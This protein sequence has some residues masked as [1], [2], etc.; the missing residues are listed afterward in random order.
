MSMQKIAFLV[1]VAV[2]LW[3]G[4]WN[5]HSILINNNSAVYQSDTLKDSTAFVKDPLRLASFL[6]SQDTARKDTLPKP[7]VGLQRDTTYR[8][9]TTAAPKVAALQTELKIASLAHLS[10]CPGVFVSVSFIADGPFNDGNEFTVQIADATGKFTASSEPAK[11]GPLRTLIPINRAG[12]FAVRV[13][14]SSPYL[15]SKPTQIY[16]LPLPTARIEFTDG[17]FMTKIGPGQATTYRVNLTGAAPWSFTLSDGTTVTNTFINPYTATVQPTQTTAYKATD[18]GNV[19]GSGT[20]SGEVIVQVSQDT[21]PVIALKAV[22]KGGYRVCS[23]AALQVNF[24][25]TGKYQI[26]NGFVVQLADSLSEKFVNISEL[27]ENPVVAKIPNNLTPGR[28]KMRLVS[29]FP[30]QSSDTADVFVSATTTTLLRTDSLEVAEGQSANLT[31]EFKG[32]EPWFVLLSDGTY[33]NDI[34][35]SIY[36]I[37]VMPYNSAVYSI[38]SAGGYC[39]VGDFSGRAYVNVKIPPTTLST[40]NLSKQTICAGTEIVVPFTSTGRFY[41]ANQFVVQI[42]DTAGKWVNLPTTGAAGS[43]RA[44]ISPP[45]LRD[46]ISVQQIRVISTAPAAQGTPTTLKVYKPNVAE[47][48]V[49]GGGFIRPGGASRLKVTF[50]NGLPPYSFTLSDGTLVNGT[51]INPYQMTVSPRNTTD[52]KITGLTTACGTG[53]GAGSATVKVETN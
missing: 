39:G 46:T 3:G 33:Q 18:I 28:Y 48:L 32:G 40:G 50:K 1:S 9:D 42:A 19:C 17:G 44:K 23:G 22:P 45:F 13:V 47:A 51:F 36:K 4:L 34:R 26:G 14:S 37:K 11:R 24:N 41:A 27:G 25:A 52:F 5:S 15:E 49:T 12:T 7:V 16:I 8:P 35:S 2:A 10:V 29:T 6:P 31:V 53:S 38:T 43:L 30:T 21:L 20:V